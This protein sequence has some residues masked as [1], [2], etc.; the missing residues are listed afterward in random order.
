M[1]PQSIISFT[2]TKHSKSDILSLIK[3]Y[4]I[5]MNNNNLAQNSNEDEISKQISQRNNGENSKKNS[6]MEKIANVLRESNRTDAKNLKGSDIEDFQKAFIYE[7]ANKNNLWVEDLYS[8]GVATGIG[9]N[10]NTL[11]YNKDEGVLY[12]SNNLYN[13]KFLI[14]NFFEKLILHNLTFLNTKYTFVGFTGHQRRNTPYIEPIAKQDFI[15]DATQAT[16]EDIK[17]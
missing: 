17:T 16:V 7:Y 13:V 10:E 15:Q 14:S 3:K 5:V 6:R 4:K 11:A 1:F 9:G 2:C 8:L 12:K